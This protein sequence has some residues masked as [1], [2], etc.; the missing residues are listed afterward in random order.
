VAREKY[1]SLHPGGMTHATTSNTK[2]LGAC[3]GADVLSTFACSQTMLE[4]KVHFYLLVGV[5][6][7]MGCI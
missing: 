6:F 2:A 5:S 7:K 4:L 3:Q 1:Q